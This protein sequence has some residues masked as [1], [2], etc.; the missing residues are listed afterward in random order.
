MRARGNK[1]GGRH[2]CFDSNSSRH[3]LSP[4]GEPGAVVE[5]SSIFV[6]NYLDPSRHW[7][8]RIVHVGWMNCGLQPQ[9][10]TGG[11]TLRQ[12]HPAAG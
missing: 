10:A 8:E 12:P 9:I 7:R 1:R 5:T 6:H 4:V 3:L 11:M 2:R